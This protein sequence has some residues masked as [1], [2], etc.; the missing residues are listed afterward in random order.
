[1]EGA[2]FKDLNILVNNAG[3][4]RD[5]NFTKG[6]DAFLPGERGQNQPGS[7]HHLVRAVC[8][9][10]IGKNQ[11][12]IVNVSP[13]SGLCRR[14]YAGLQRHQGWSARLLHGAQHQLSKLGIKVFEVV[15]PA[16][17]TELNPEGRANGATSRRIS[18]PRNSWRGHERP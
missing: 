18:S 13:G 15:P 4:Q 16:V 5:I 17:D 7:A 12:A 11:P 8:P 2:S 6:V 3:V 1:M 10:V 9:P 14:A